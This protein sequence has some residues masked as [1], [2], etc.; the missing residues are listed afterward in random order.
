MVVHTQAKSRLSVVI[1]LVLTV[2]LLYLVTLK[3]E[4]GSINQWRQ[5]Q[6]PSWTYNK[7]TN[8]TI[9]NAGYPKS[10]LMYGE[11]KQAQEFVPQQGKGKRVLILA[12]W[13]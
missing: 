2:L 12:Y 6:I 7:S 4:S 13:R 3:S 8:D 9:E 5:S 10:L 11:S 1:P